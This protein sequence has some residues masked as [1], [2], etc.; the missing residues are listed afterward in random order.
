MRTIRSE[1]PDYDGE[2]LH[3]APFVCEPWH[4]DMCPRYVWRCEDGE[5]TLWV[6]YVDPARREAQALRFYFTVADPDEEIVASF[7]AETEHGLRV[8]LEYWYEYQVGYNPD[9]GT[10]LPL[11]ELMA[12]VARYVLEEAKS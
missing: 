3:I 6:D 2:E 8:N 4:N 11:G 7:E 1:F 9:E 5:A 12:A 10:P